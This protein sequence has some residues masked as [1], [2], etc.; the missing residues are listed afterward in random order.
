MASQIYK[1]IR[2]LFETHAK[3]NPVSELYIK[4]KLILKGID[5]DK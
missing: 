2:E 1:E 3:D 5:P 4:T